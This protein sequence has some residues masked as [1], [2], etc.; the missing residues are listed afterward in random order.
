[1]AKTSGLASSRE[2]QAASAPTSA[3][4]VNADAETAL[5]SLVLLALDADERADE[6]RHR[7]VP[8]HDRIE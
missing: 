7:E 8:D 3:I 5:G 6:H 2:S 4:S 1:V